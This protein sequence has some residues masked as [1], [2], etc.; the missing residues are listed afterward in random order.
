ME[1]AES[2]ELLDGLS[3][4]SGSAGRPRKYPK[5]IAGDKGYDSQELREKMRAR[6]IKPEI[7]KRQ[8][9]DKPKRGRPGKLTV[10]RYIVERAHAWI[11]R[12]YRRLVVRWERLPKCFEC[13]LKIGIVH[14]W[15]TKL[16]G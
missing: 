13:F 11:Q 5:I 2:T 12:K 14:F 1:R 15:I 3:V 7:P 6:G 8:W 10:P 9:K 16:V 4:K